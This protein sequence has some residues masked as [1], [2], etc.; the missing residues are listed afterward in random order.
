MLAI[1]TKPEERKSKSKG[2]RNNSRFVRSTESH[3]NDHSCICNSIKGTK[4]Y[5]SKLK[6]LNLAMNQIPDGA[7][8]KLALILRNNNILTDLNLSNNF[9]KDD[10]ASK[11][12]NILTHNFT[13]QTITL[14]RNSMNQQTKDKI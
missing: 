1:G 3:D 14:D 11:L 10:T 12:L 8:E 2:K 7:G 13:L 6:T 5:Y 9:L 4:K